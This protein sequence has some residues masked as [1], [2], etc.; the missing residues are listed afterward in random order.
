MIELLK[1][2]P[3]NVVGVVCTGRVTAQD[4]TRVLVPA[5]E[6]ALGQNQKVRLYYQVDQDF[7]AYD[8]SAMWE[9]FKVGVA[10][11]SR[12]ERIAVVTDL[13]WIRN[14]V[15]IFGFLMPAAV[16]VFPLSAAAAARE[17]VVAAEEG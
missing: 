3:A 8:A 6:H 5:V 9:D 12:W 16:Q 13:D 11:L 7:Q 17:W 14:T 2:F 10:H 1:D 15:R 4:Y